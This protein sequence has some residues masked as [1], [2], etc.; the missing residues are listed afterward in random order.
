MTLVTPENEVSL[1][2]RSRGPASPISLSLA[3]RCCCLR[4]VIPD[5]VINETRPEERREAEFTHSG[6]PD[7]DA[8][9]AVTWDGADDARARQMS[10]WLCAPWRRG[11]SRSARWQTATRSPQFRGEAVALQV[12]NVSTWE[13]EQQAE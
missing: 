2:S 3:T 12:N 10:R 11:E 4:D 7:A 6:H 9:P 1:A 8:V 13:Q 5:M